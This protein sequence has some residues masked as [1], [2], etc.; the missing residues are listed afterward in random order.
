MV[1]N[2][3]AGRLI[4]NGKLAFVTKAIKLP[5]AE[6][7]HERAVLAYTEHG[8]KPV[9]VPIASHR[10]FAEFLTNVSMVL[11]RDPLRST[12]LLMKRYIFVQDEDVDHFQIRILALDTTTAISCFEKVSC[13]FIQIRVVDLKFP[14][15][16]QF[17][18]F[19]CETINVI[20]ADK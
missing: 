5:A 2:V 7:T 15:I 17:L 9:S 1:S 8:G 4:G 11:G 3:F 10:F 12:S 19:C 20:S 18:F 16:F 14:Y 6:D 13:V